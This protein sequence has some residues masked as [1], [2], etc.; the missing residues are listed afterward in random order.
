MKYL[1]AFIIF[2]SF[3]IATSAQGFIPGSYIGLPL[4]NFFRPIPALDTTA[5][6]KW[7]VSKFGELTMGITAFR[8]GSA[9]FVSAPVGLQ[10]T[11]KLNNNL[12]AFGAVSVAPT[13]INFGQSFLNG[14]NS[15]TFPANTG[16]MYQP[17]QLMI[18]PRAE[19]GLMYTNDERT[20]QISGS[21]GIER[22][23]YPMFGG[24]VPATQLQNGQSRLQP[25]R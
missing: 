10:L 7:S 11:R 8:G 13:Y 21:I 25:L 1:Y 22:R 17:N 5:K 15:K 20:F 19:I 14:G 12:Y 4:N 18:S 6:S 16:F 3:S 2:C 23:Q 9:S 24:Y